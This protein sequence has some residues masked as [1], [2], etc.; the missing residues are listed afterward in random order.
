VGICLPEAG[1]QKWKGELFMVSV[2][3]QAAQKL[4]VSVKASRRER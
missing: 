3:L 2:L 4:G 1:N